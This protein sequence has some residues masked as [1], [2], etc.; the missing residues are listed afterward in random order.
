LIRVLTASMAMLATSAC[1]V[2]SIDETTVFEPVAY[3][4]ALAERTGQKMTG[5]AAFNSEADWNGVWASRAKA[6]ARF[7][8]TPAPYVAAKV[9]HGRFGTREGGLAYTTVTRAAPSDTLVV[10]CGGNSSTRQRSGYRYS[11]V[12]VPHGDVLLF[13]YPGYGE[14]AGEASPARFQQMSDEIVPLV[15]EKA[16][17]RKIVLWGHSLGGLVCSELAARMPEVDGVIIE[18]SARNAREVAQAWTPWYA[19]PFVRIEI[20]EGFESVDVANALKGFKGPVL[21]LGGEKDET[22]PVQL[23]RSVGKALKD[24][25]VAAEYVE[26]KGG[27]HS[28]LIL[29]ESFAPTINAFFAKVGAGA[30]T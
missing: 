11:V 27:G 1:M 10:R 25:G 2:V 21:V 19:A 4:A 8:K 17:G 13:D 6:D 14:T 30:G 23:A 29:Q 18:T 12:A 5:E 24:E 20:K 16:A 3:D 9:E 7:P 28:D 26:F 22:L 15:R